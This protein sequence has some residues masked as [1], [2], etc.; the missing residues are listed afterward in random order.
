MPI[1]QRPESGEGNIAQR[2]R[3]NSGAEEGRQEGH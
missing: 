2:K 1:T 3:N